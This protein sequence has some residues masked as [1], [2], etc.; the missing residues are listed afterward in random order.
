MQS[1]LDMTFAAL[2]DPTRRA[3]LI[4][5]ARG[6]TTVAELQKPFAISQPAISKHLKVLEVAG[7][8][9]RR[10]SAQSRP[11][12]LNAAALNEA[13][14]WLRHVRTLWGDSFD[15]LDDFLNET[16]SATEEG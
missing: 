16:R 1:L 8:I 11:R 4:R 14:A 10:Q 9:E 13:T 12:H 3:I 5:L 6:D 7:L 15:Q 2:A